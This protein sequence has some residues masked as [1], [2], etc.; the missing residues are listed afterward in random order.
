LTIEPQIDSGPYKHGFVV[1]DATRVP[2]GN[3]TLIV[4]TFIPQQLGTFH[5]QVLS[6]SKAVTVEQLL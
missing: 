6:S 3:Y 5:L 2:A 4:S 1:V